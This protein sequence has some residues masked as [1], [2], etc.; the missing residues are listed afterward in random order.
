MGDAGV[1]DGAK[2]ETETAY[3][4]F[5]ILGVAFNLQLIKILINIRDLLT[6]LS[7]YEFFTFDPLPF[8]LLYLC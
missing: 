1:G 5:K 2:T 7:I 3:L 4:D 6:I 8:K